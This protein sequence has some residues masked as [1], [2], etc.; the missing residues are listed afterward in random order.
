MNKV[1]NPDIINPAY[2]Q[3]SRKEAAAILGVSITEFNR[4]RKN[5]SRCPT[6]FKNSDS[7][8]AQVKFR[9]SDIYVYSEALMQD[10][11]PAT[12]AASS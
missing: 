10:M 4:M 9:L 2:V 8:F 5:D 6:G 1:L 11:I 3:I 12:T 7:Q